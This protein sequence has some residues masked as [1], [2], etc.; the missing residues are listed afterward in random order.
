MSDEATM[1]YASDAEI[2]TLVARFAS[3]EL[4][5][6]EVSHRAHVAMSVWC[7]LKLPESEAAAR[8]RDDLRRYVEWHGITVYNETMTLFWIKLI[9]KTVAGLDAAR[10]VFERANDVVTQLGDSRRIFTYY[11]RERLQ[12]DEARRGWVEPDLQP[13]DF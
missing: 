5:P 12:M 7:F 9:S 4:P 11:T 6:D 3:C 2:E 13:L 10:P 1:P 8:I